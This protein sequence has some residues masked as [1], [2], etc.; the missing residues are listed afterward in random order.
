MTVDDRKR[1]AIT[2]KMADQEY[3]QPVKYVS[4]IVEYKLYSRRGKLAFR[5]VKTGEM[6]PVELKAL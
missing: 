6:S 4:P 2:Q 3:W 1:L 5:N